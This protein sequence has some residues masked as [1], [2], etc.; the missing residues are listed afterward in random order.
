MKGGQSER[1]SKLLTGQFGGLTTF[2]GLS[3]ALTGGVTLK[4]NVDL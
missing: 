4:N 2:D 1:I 3:M